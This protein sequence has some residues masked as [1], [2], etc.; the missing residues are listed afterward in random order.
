M[1]HKHFHELEDYHLMLKRDHSLILSALNW[2]DDASN[3]S[4]QKTKKEAIEN[5]LNLLSNWKTSTYECLFPEL[6]DC[7]DQAIKEIKP[8]T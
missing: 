7:Y 4:S 5:A 6:E 2:L 1:P 8:D 3:S